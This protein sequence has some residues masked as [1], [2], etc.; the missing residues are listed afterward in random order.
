VWPPAP[1]V[2]STIVAPL[3]RS[4]PGN[5]SSRLSRSMTGAWLVESKLRHQI[6]HAVRGAAGFAPAAGRP[7]LDARQGTDQ[8]DVA[9]DRGMI[10]Q[11]LRHDDATLAVE[12]HLFGVREEMAH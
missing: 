6:R 10:A 7:H 11:S 8:D 3:V 5:K 1:N 4:R 12:R 2:A 9:I